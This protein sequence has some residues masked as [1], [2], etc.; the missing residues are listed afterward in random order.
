MNPK[1]ALRAGT[2][3]LHI[4]LLS[5]GTV[6]LAMP[7]AAAAA[8]SVSQYQKFDGVYR[9]TVANNHWLD[10]DTASGR[11]VGT[12]WYRSDEGL[13][14]RS[15]F[16]IND[17][18]STPSK[19]VGT[20]NAGGSA[21]YVE[22]VLS[23]DG[24]GLAQLEKYGDLAVYS[25][26]RRVEQLGS[27]TGS[28]NRAQ[29]EARLRG[30]WKTP[31]G[32]LLIEGGPGPDRTGPPMTGKLFRPDG[33]TVRYLLGG[34][35]FQGGDD[36][37]QAVWN[38]RT[39][40]TTQ[41]GK[42][43]I[44]AISPD[45]T[46]LSAYNDSAYNG[47][48]A[49]P[50]GGLG[51]W[52][53]TKE[54]ATPW[55]SDTAS[56]PAPMPAPNTDSAV[57]F[58]W[59]GIFLLSRGNDDASQRSYVQFTEGYTSMSVGTVWS[60]KSGQI[61]QDGMIVVDQ[62]QSGP[63]AMVGYFK[64]AL[65]QPGT[66]MTMWGSAGNQFATVLSDGR[67]PRPIYFRRVSELGANPS[68]LIGQALKD[69]AVGTWNTPH[70]L[71]TVSQ[72]DGKTVG[73]LTKPG[74]GGVFH[75]LEVTGTD[76]EVLNWQS[77]TMSEDRFEMLISPDGQEFQAVSM[78]SR[79]AIGDLQNWSGKRV[80]ATAP[81][82]QPQ[83]QPQPPA[84]T[85]APAPAPTPPAPVPAPPPTPP[86]V[87][88]PSTPAAGTVQAGVFHQLERFDVRVDEVRAAR[89]GKVHLFLTAANKSGG[90]RSIGQGTF[91]VVMSDA[92][93]VGVLTETAWRAT[94]E[95]PKTFD[96][97]PTVPAGGE[98]KVRYIL[99]PAVVHGPL[100]RIGVRESSKKVLYFDARAADA[101][102]EPNAPPPPGGGAFKSLTK[103][104]VR[105][106]R[107]AP[108]RDGRLEAYLTLRNPTRDPQSATAAG[109]RLSGTNSDG[110]AVTARYALYSARGERGEN[111]ALPV[112]L[113]VEAGGET[114]VRY[115]F[116]DAP[117]GALTITDGTATQTFT[118]G[119]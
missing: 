26:F 57:N 90:A 114:R 74:G 60:L 116:D 52:L 39:P 94:G 46:M 13:E 65:S 61:V 98:F 76:G 38:W 111:D 21:R 43:L 37:E 49:A 113:Y 44:I 55:V 56:A 47:G 16:V 64:T 15:N 82:P 25:F 81:Q 101:G 97:P 72:A 2:A 103:L 107:V 42:G 29:V 59:R 48:V 41:S 40:G 34:P 14:R 54:G 83:P 85:P 20:Y 6:P 78:E 71:L 4:L 89:D 86:V 63:H 102:S 104:D 68:T 23:P 50:L 18:L 77:K 117:A 95:E 88:Q 30:R 79:G 96:V 7:T 69:A 1:P 91:T 32:D 3:A 51:S 70:G 8:T 75:N 105:I 17:S 87:Q 92:D 35:L 24:N 80:A 84:P 9:L 31:L 108:A 58:D 110:S 22:F 109:L 11:L 62:A 118:P 10:L 5:A 67:P 33:T 106:D 66:K 93:G 119:G 12:L 115:V 36:S 19:L 53:A 28:L 27:R 112:P 73:V 99:Q 100:S 45:G